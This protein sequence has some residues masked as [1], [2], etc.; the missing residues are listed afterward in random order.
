MNYTLVIGNGFDL[1][2]QLPSS[3]SDY[4]YFLRSEKNTKTGRAVESFCR[5]LQD[6]LG[7][8]KTEVRSNALNLGADCENLNTWD[9]VFLTMGHADNERMAGLRWM[10][11][12]QAIHD[13]VLGT[14]KYFNFSP[15]VCSEHA[16]SHM[17]VE[18][19]A[20]YSRDIY[21]I[22][23]AALSRKKAFANTTRATKYDYLL[24]ELNDFERSFSK[25]LIDNVG[26][27]YF[28]KALFLLDRLL[29]TL[30]EHSPVYPDDCYLV[31]YNYVNY[32]MFPKCESAVRISSVYHLTNIHGSL[33]EK[34]SVLLGMT[35]TKTELKGLINS[36]TGELSLEGN[37]KYG[38]SKEYRRIDL[39]RTEGDSLRIPSTS[40]RYLFFGC[41]F[42]RQ[43]YHSL[44]RFF[45]HVIGSKKEVLSG[46]REGR[47][48]FAYSI[49]NEDEKGSIIRNNYLS[50][51][52]A[53]LAWAAERK[54]EWRD[55]LD[56]LIDANMVYFEEIKRE[57][58]WPA[59]ILEPR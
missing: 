55:I 15:I 27:E 42:S 39:L 10:D 7:G 29:F 50:V 24:T 18:A 26:E 4:L 49:Y 44:F 13:I 16:R 11:V 32:S 5:F 58:S 31:S 47:L 56:D 9:L 33:G 28:Y 57:E 48:V 35:P 8:S 14:G 45:D 23:G 20:Y 3:F 38:F 40:G 22:L 46:E 41:S 12:E 34:R 51:K 43:D 2:C 6:G 17:Q 52:T 54:Q 1:A 36:E 25:Y 19:V 30:S 53:L 59:G 37:L 21:F